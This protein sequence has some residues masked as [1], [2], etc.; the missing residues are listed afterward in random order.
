MHKRLFVL[1]LVPLVFTLI[2]G[3]NTDNGT[4]TVRQIGE[5]NSVLADGIAAQV[6]LV[7]FEAGSGTPIILQ[8]ETIFTLNNEEMEALW[9]TYDAG[10][11]IVLLDAEE[12]E[13]DELI[14]IIDDGISY[15]SG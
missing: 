13:V 15:R 9:E 8:G 2:G 5:L 14:D 4:F 7:P 3:C 11:S 1:V 10:L 6:R 12:P